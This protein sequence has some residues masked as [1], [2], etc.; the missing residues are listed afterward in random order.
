VRVWSC[1]LQ[2]QFLVEEGSEANPRQLQGPGFLSDGS[3][4]MGWKLGMVCRK[5]WER[6]KSG[7]DGF[8]ESSK[9]VSWPGLTVGSQA[10]RTPR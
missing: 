10:H 8:A 2:A 4:L 5:T 7:L 1:L 6:M 3:A 9:S